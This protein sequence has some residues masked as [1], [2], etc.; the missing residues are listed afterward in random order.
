M[1]VEIDEA[2]RRDPELLRD[3]EAATA[4]LLSL[5]E[6]T[7]PPAVARWVPVGGRA[8]RPT[9]DTSLILTLTDHADYDSRVVDRLLPTRDVRDGDRRDQ[10]V[11]SLWTKL[12]QSRSKVLSDRVATAISRIDVTGG[13]DG[14]Q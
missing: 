8:D 2:I 4:Y 14:G 11:R 3:V 6:W 10:A 13:D 1:T 12:L 9:T 5:H 7:G